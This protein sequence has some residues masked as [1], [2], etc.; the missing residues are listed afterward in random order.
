[1]AKTKYSYRKKKQYVRNLKQY[2]WKPCTKVQKEK[3]ERLPSGYKFEFKENNPPEPT[4][5]MIEKE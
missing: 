4:P 5:N 2:E 3:I 1:M